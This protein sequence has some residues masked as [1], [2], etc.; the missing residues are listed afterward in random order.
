[1]KNRLVKGPVYAINKPQKGGPQEDEEWVWVYKQHQNCSKPQNR[2]GQAN[3]VGWGESIL[4][5]YQRLGWNWEDINVFARHV[6]VDMP[7]GNG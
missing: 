5:S 3:A 4:S 7:D 2:E 6:F 1:M